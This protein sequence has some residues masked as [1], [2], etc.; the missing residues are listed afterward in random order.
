MSLDLARGPFSSP[1]PRSFWPAAEIESSG[2]AQHQKSAI[3]GLPDKSGNLIGWE[4][5]TIT[6]HMLRKSVPAGWAPGPGQSSRSLPQVRRIVALGTR[7]ARG[8]DFSSAWQKG[9][10]PGTRLDSGEIPASVSCEEGIWSYKTRL[11]LSMSNKFSLVFH[12]V[13]E[14]LL[15]LITRENFEWSNVEFR[16]VQLV[17]Q[18]VM[19]KL[20]IFIICKLTNWRQFVMRLSCYWS[21][22]SWISS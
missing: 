14:K 12:S 17:F 1:E 11:Y 19:E 10:P 7:M 20:L 22:W 3:H 2:F 8:P 13:M 6:L 21:C 16:Y 9:T 18:S 4:Y 15:I 5:E